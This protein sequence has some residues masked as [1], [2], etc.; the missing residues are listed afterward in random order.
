MDLEGSMSFDDNVL[1]YDKYRTTYVKE[2]FDDLFAYSNCNENSHVIEIGCGTGQATSWVLDRGCTLKAIEIG[3][4]LC[5]F[6]KNKF[7]NYPKLE[8]INMPFEEYTMQENSVDMVFSA[9]AFHWIPEDIGYPKVYNALKKGGCFAIIGCPVEIADVNAELKAE[10][11]GIEREYLPQNTGTYQDEYNIM[12]QKFEL[13]GFHDIIHNQYSAFRELTAEEYVGLMMSVSRISKLSGPS[14]DLLFEKI[15]N[16]I[17]K[18]RSI[19]IHDKMDLY[20]GRK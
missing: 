9:S 12:Q 14:R 16:V 2:L 10:V 19:Q 5:D 11:E 13:Y 17:N 8:V 15:R 1:N 7:K 20:M 4:N 18:H 3:K 6:T